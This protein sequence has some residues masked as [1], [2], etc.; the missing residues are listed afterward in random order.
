M[1]RKIFH[2]VEKKLPN[3]EYILNMI[4][5][6]IM[7]PGEKRP[8]LKKPE[9]IL[10]PGIR[11]R[12]FKEKI[13][14]VW[15][16]IGLVIAS[17]SLAGINT[18]LQN[19]KIP[20]ERATQQEKSIQ[21]KEIEKLKSDIE[22]IERRQEELNAGVDGP[23]GRAIGAVREWWERPA[24]RMMQPET[25]VNTLRAR[26]KTLEGI[27][28]V[29]GKFDNSIEYLNNKL[30]YALFIAFFVAYTALLKTFIE[31]LIDA[32]RETLNDKNIADQ[33]HAE[34]LKQYT[35]I[36]EILNTLVQKKDEA[37]NPDNKRIH[38][39]KDKL[40]S[41]LDRL[42]QTEKKVLELTKEK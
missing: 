27:Q 18:E 20:Y 8:K 17:G 15:K 5:T 16:W 7:N 2:Q 9:P 22:K 11:E 13:D 1:L 30:W 10:V 36:E 3:L 25:W 32:R 23:V 24:E 19:V 33:V 14:T 34:L 42:E 6:S 21:Q 41:I 39:D 40:E 38:V 29:G 26:L 4:Y 37:E 12:L 31:R 35:N 28:F